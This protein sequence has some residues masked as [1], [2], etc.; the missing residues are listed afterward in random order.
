MVEE[1]LV[2][3]NKEQEGLIGRQEVLDAVEEALLQYGKGEAKVHPQR[4]FYVPREDGERDRYY[5]VAEKDGAV[6][7]HNVMGLRVDS[8]TLDVVEKRGNVRTEFPQPFSG[9]V[10]L[11]DI[12]TNHL[13]AILQ[14]Y[15]LNPTRVTATNAIMIDYL[16]KENAEVMGVFGSGAMATSQTLLSCEV[17]DFETVKIYSTNEG[18]RE[19][20]ADRM[21]EMTDASIDIMAADSPKETVEGSD[22][23]AACTSSA[24]PVFDGEWLEP[25]THVSTLAASD[26]FLPRR[27]TDDTTVERSDLIVVNDKGTIERHKQLELYPPIRRGDLKMDDIY[28]VGEIVNK[29]THGRGGTDQITYHN[30]NAAIGIPYAVLGKIIYEKAKKRDLGT[31]L[32]ADLFM[33]YDDDLRDIQKG[34][35]LPNPDEYERKQQKSSEETSRE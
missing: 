18:R 35:F 28:H 21:N 2:L 27:E 10:L 29:K 30:N 12:E 4:H 25:G 34:G 1:T 7:S 14:D 3:T 20:F 33:Q 11:F 32:D 26:D 31:A 15:L 23:V 24:E 9:L 17:R 5:W 16:A 6:P 22:V 8:A 13:L 19:S